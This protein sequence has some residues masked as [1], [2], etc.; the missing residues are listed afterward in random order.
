MCLT[1]AN[2]LTSYHLAVQGCPRFFNSW[3]ATCPEIHTRAVH[4]IFF[5]VSNDAVIIGP[6]S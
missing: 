5:F 6:L 4:M 2:A 3:P 1:A